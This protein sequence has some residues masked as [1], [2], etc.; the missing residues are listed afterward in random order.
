MA[1]TKSPPTPSTK[2][3]AKT[4]SPPAQVTL[5][6]EIPLNISFKGKLLGKTPAQISLPPGKSTLVLSNKSAGIRIRRNVDLRA[7]QSLSLNVQ[8]EKGTLNVSAPTGAEIWVDGTLKGK[9]PMGDI[10]LWEGDHQL[11]VKHGNDALS[12]NFSLNPG[13]YMNYDVR[14]TSA[15][16]Y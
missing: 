2:T 9:A 15:P 5:Q 1:K 11:L 6:S 7:G 13:G 16:R 10:E 8:L 4:A 3:S 12:E 14:Q